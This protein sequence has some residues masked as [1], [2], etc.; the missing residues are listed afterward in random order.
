MTSILGKNI[1]LVRPRLIKSFGKLKDAW[2][3]RYNYGPKTRKFTDE[4]LE[5]L[6]AHYKKENKNGI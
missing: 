3:P 2:R 5:D 6:K 1:D 4:E